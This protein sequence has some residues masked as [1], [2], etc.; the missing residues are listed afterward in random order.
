[1]DVKN[2]SGQE[3]TD[4]VEFGLQ[5]RLVVPDLVQR[6]GEKG[7][8]AGTQNAVGLDERPIEF[9]IAGDCISSIW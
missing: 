2:R 8:D 6:Q 1:M 3:R 9:F 4:A 5:S 7:F